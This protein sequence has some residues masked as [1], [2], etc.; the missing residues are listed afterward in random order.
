[1][2][3]S[4]WSTSRFYSYW[5]ASHNQLCIDEG[6]NYML[7][8]Y[9]EAQELKEILEAFIHDWEEEHDG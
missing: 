7:L 9:E 5:H 2:S 4:R 8:T 6:D 3:Y 1:M